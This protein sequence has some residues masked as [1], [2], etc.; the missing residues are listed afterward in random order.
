MR[1]KL[2]QKAKKGK[3]PANPAGLCP[4]NPAPLPGLRPVTQEVSVHGRQARSS[5]EV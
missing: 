3:G 2:T 5:V 4:R 1:P